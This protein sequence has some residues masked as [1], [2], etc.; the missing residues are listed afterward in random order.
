MVRS[1]L[2][3]LERLARK[4][5]RE[6]GQLAIFLQAV[7]YIRGDAPGLHPDTNEFEGSLF[8]SS[9]GVDRD[10]NEFYPRDVP[11]LSE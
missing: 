8:R 4:R 3:R 11:D 1:K 6:D 2:E 7:D 5:K 10:G 9:T